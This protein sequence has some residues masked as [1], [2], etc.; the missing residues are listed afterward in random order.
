MIRPQSEI[1]FPPSE[2]L[3]AKALMLSRMQALQ[4]STHSLMAVIAQRLDAEQYQKIQ[5]VDKYT[6]EQDRL[7]ENMHKLAR[8]GLTSADRARR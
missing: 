5:D 3:K 6:A 7:I 4:N 8:G 1:E 2:F